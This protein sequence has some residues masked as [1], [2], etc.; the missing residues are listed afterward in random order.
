MPLQGA[1]ENSR[2][3]HRPLMGPHEGSEGPI[4][5]S[6]GRSR[7]RGFHIGPTWVPWE[8]LRI[9]M[10]AQ[11]G[12][13]APPGGAREFEDFTQA[14]HGSLGRFLESSRGLRGAHMP[15]QGALENS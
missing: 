11:R 6:R 3:S 15:L 13:Y 4:C 9:L 2:I 14:P 1:L 5:P 7:I 10:R 8:V 12:P